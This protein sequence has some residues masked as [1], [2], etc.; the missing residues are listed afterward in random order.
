MS[1]KTNTT[2]NQMSGKR[3]ATINQMSGAD[4]VHGLKGEL[5]VQ[6]YEMNKADN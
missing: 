5:A 2:I 4:T 1:G 3:N 6:Q